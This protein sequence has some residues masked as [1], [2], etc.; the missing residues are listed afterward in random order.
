MTSLAE[1][2]PT[3]VG[4]GS[5]DTGMWDQYLIDQSSYSTDEASYN[6]ITSEYT[7]A[8]KELDTLPTEEAFMFIMM[9]LLIMPIDQQNAQI[10]VLGDEMNVSSDY[11]TNI[12]SLENDWE[13][14]LSN[15]IESVASGDSSSAVSAQT[16]DSWV[17][18]IDMLNNYVQSDPTLNSS[19]ISTVT[20]EISSL[21][22]VFGTNAWPTDPNSSTF[23]EQCD[24]MITTFNTKIYPAAQTDP[25]TNSY[26]T[27]VD[28][29]FQTLNQ[30][31][32]GIQT[33]L[34]SE[35]SFQSEMQQQYMT[36]TENQYNTYATNLSTI[37]SNY[38]TS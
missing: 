30:S 10:A 31:F 5:Y 27:T 24:D 26:V 9:V 38:K 36:A 28:N 6:T 4:A 37:I 33:S 14:F 18:N 21:E 35:V 7:S 23:Q 34:N 17:Y 19:T 16:F 25:T 1:N 3:N 29:S 20:S 13:S 8:L 15:G 22:S 12:A 2:N 32:S 11:Q